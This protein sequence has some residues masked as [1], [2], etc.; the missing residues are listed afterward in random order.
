MGKEAQLLEAAAA[1][2]NIK[3]EVSV[4]Y[5]HI[6]EHLGGAVTLLV[7][8]I[9]AENIQCCTCWLLNVTY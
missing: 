5:E 4:V 2:N 6:R 9:S 3:V 8:V 7:N 1:G